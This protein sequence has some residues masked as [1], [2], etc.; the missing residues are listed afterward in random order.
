MLY[1]R[2]SDDELERAVYIDPA[3]TAARNEMLSRLPALLE[4]AANGD[5]LE[6][7]KIE[8]AEREVEVEN[9]R[10]EVTGLE[11]D[12]SAGDE[13]INTLQSELDAAKARIADLTRAE[14][15]V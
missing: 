7:V 2:H 4:G 13:V 8:L 9:L 14:D 11:Q 5:A 3:N 1:N 10:D 12:V 15:L 6:G